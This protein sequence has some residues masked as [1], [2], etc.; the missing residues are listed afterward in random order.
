MKKTPVTKKQ[1]I[2]RGVL[3][4]FGTLVYILLV[5]LIFAGEI[6]WKQLLYM[7]IGFFI[8]L[9]IIVVITYKFMNK[10]KKIGIKLNNLFK[11]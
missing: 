4:F 10:Y 2:Q 7:A 8:F 9:L 5:M 3:I 11:H 1:A 6:F